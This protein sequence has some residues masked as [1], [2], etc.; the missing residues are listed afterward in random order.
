MHYYLRRPA[1]MVHFRSFKLHVSYDDAWTCCYPTW[2]FSLSVD[3][4]D[5]VH[6]W[7]MTW[8]KWRSALPPVYPA[9]TVVRRSTTSCP[10]QRIPWIKHVSYDDAWTCCYPTWSFPLSVDIIDLWHNWFMTWLQWR[11]ALPPVYPAGTVVRRSI[12]SCPVQRIPI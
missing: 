10:V 9:G 5:C 12:T 2:C 3:I 6:N 1:L 8:L 7:F 11:N 4:T